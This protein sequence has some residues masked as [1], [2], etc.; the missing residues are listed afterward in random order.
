MHLQTFCSSEGRDTLLTAVVGW[1][2]NFLRLRRSWPWPEESSSATASSQGW[3]GEELSWM[4]E[5]GVL[6]SFHRAWAQDKLQTSQTTAWIN[7]SCLKANSK[8]SSICR[9]FFG[10]RCWGARDHVTQAGSHVWLWQSRRECGDLGQAGWKKLVDGSDKENLVKN[11]FKQRLLSGFSHHLES[12][13]QRNAGFA[14]DLEKRGE[15]SQGNGGNV[16]WQMGF[17][18]GLK[19]LWRVLE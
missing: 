17:S 8:P 4:G 3:A 2:R 18:T 5:F 12:G 15:A 14:G 9:C 6:V 16:G 7:R 11:F 19:A 13:F 10:R 1:S